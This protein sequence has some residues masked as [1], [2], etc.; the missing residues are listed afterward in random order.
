MLTYPARP[1]SAARSPSFRLVSQRRLLVQLCDV[2]E[3]RRRLGAFVAAHGA[4]GAGAGAGEHGAGGQATE[5]QGDE[6]LAA[7]AEAVRQLLA[8]YDAQLQVGGGGLQ[9]RAHG[10]GL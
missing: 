5:G 6:C 9:A 7:F 10:P 3:L 1:Y 8:L 2:G 4:A